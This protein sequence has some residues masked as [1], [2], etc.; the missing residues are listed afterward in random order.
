M[1]CGDFSITHLATEKGIA[2]LKKLKIDEVELRKH[3]L[4]TTK[5][6]EISY[7][8]HVQVLKA[9]NLVL[10]PAHPNHQFHYRP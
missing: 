4:M 9:Q 7:T 2:T 8:L 6:S 1:L 10:H 3:A 5:D